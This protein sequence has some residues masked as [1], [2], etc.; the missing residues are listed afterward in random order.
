MTKLTTIQALIVAMIAPILGA[1]AGAKSSAKELPAQTWPDSP[2][3]KI[4]A[5]WQQIETETK[6]DLFS[7]APQRP[8]AWSVPSA[9]PNIPAW[10]AVCKLP[11]TA[12]NRCTD[13]CRLASSIC[14]NAQQICQIAEEIAA[15][16]QA[17]PWASEKCSSATE[18]CGKS[19][20]MC[21]GC[22][23]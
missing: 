5:L 18:R 4:E 15:N 20:A 21:C 11:D 13:T 1:C 9:T 17:D 2:R 14:S 3:S 10:E 22:D 6:T 7:G 16:G 8:M 23:G 19:K 12:S